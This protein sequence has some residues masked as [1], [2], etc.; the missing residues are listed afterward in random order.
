MTL[1]SMVKC[2]AL[3]C[4]SLK[5]GPLGAFHLRLSAAFLVSAPTAAVP[6]SW[7]VGTWPA[8]EAEAGT[9]VTTETPSTRD[10]ATT[11]GENL[12]TNTH[13]PGSCAGRTP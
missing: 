11:T 3:R 4:G 1:R 9:P 5:K 7:L 10:R 13:L 12:D 6:G 8:S 2:P